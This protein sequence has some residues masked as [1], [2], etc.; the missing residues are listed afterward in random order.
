MSCAYRSLDRERH[1]HA[2]ADAQRRQAAARAAALQLVQKRDHD[3]RAGRADRMPEGNRTAV[4]VQPIGRDGRVAQHGQHLRGE[5]LVQLDQIEVVD[6]EAD[7]IAQLLNRRHRADAHD[8][9]I[10]AGARPP[11]DFRARSQ[12]AG[13]R[14]LRRRQHQRG[15]PVG[16]ARRG[17]RGDDPGTPFDL[18]EDR[19]QLAQALER[20]LA[21]MLVALDRVVAVAGRPPRPAGGTVTAAISREKCPAS[22]AARALRWLSSAKQ[23]DCSRVMPYSRASTSAVSPMMRFDSGHWNPSRYIASTS[24]KFPI[25][26]PQRASTASIRYGIRLMDSMPPA[27]TMSDSPSMIDCAPDAIAWRPEAHAL[28]IV[29]AG[30]RCG[31]AGAMA[32]LTP[33]IGSGAPLAAVADQDF[34]DVRGGQAGA[35][36]G[37]ARGDGAQ[38]RRVEILERSAVPADRRARGA[39]DD[40]VRGGHKPPL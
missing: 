8:A 4:D 25:R 15:S 17:A 2:A 1:A 23:S 11:E 14:G 12:P 7:P 39:E 3:P 26:C 21:R 20:R 5:R 18:A 6:A 31:H 32:H 40:D 9:R 36:D 29:C 27:S 10:D 34:V 30:A 33:G 37:R 19:R 35:L 38:L 24:V 13:A 16:D 28:L 22:I